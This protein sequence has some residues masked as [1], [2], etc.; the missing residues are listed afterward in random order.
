M[1]TAGPQC[2]LCLSSNIERY[3]GPAPSWRNLT[4]CATCGLVSSGDSHRP[5]GGSSAPLL[6]RPHAD[7]RRA[8]AV[9][10]L[11][12]RGRI[13]E[14]GCGSGHL[15]ARLDPG[16]YEVVGLEWSPDLAREAADRLKGARVRGDVLAEGLPGARLP[17]ETFDLAALVGCLDRSPSP[18]A[19]LMEASRLLR[20]GGYAF[21]EIPCLSSLTARLR[22]SRWHPLNDPETRFFF[23][24]GSLQKLAATCGL[25]AGTVRHPFPGSGPPPGTLLYVARKTAVSLKIPELA[26]LVGE[27]GTMSPMG[28]TD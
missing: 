9:M 18:R 23:S 16:R 1:T 21:I 13:L 5:P 27:R 14:V 12:P 26:E 22:G 8:A 6:R 17:A 15:L 24:A 10:R 7:A 28:A 25:G 20:D 19:M 4:R 3:R 2:D 11:I